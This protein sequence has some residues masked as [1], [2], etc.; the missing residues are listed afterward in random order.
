MVWSDVQIDK[1]RDSKFRKN[2][3][4]QLIR[5]LNLAEL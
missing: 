5:M 4:P 2:N 1:W 3:K